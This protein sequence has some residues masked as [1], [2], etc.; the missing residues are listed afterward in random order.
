M[1]EPIVEKNPNK[2]RSSWPYVMGAIVVLGILVV[3]GWWLTS[4]QQESLPSAATDNNNEVLAVVNGRE[5]TRADLE[6]E[7]ALEEVAYYIMTKEKLPGSDRAQ[8]LE[9]LIAQQLLLEE[10]AKEGIAFEDEEVTKRIEALMDTAQL[11]EEDLEEQLTRRE[12]SRDDLHQSFRKAMI[13]NSLLRAKQEELGQSGIAQWLQELKDRAEVEI[14][15]DLS[16][17]IAPEA[18]A[19]APDFTL[20]DL[21]GQEVTLS[22]FRGQAV[23]I[24]FWATWCPPCR[25]EKPILEEAYESHK[26]ED[27]VILAVN[28][29][30]NEEEVRAFVEESGTTFPIL[31]DKSGLVISLYKV[32]AA[33]TSFFVDKEGIIIDKHMGPLSTKAIEAYLEKAR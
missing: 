5:I 16:A 33:P 4:A 20:K 15:Q 14:K 17:E 28:M 30:E 2:S 6:K 21:N 8:V 32:Y 19:K 25:F 13:T 26:G 31:L 23:L 18:G 3:G 24:N 29:R 10:A 12:L 11:S 7:I 1:R 9:R 22:D 27:F